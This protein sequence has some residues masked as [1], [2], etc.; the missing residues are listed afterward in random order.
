MPV[1]AVSPRATIDADVERAGREEMCEALG[2]PDPAI[3]HAVSCAPTGSSQGYLAY[4]ETHPPRT[5]P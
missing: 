4:K 3:N 5:L 2:G 1:S